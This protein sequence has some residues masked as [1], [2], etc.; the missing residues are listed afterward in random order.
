MH[1]HQYWWLAVFAFRLIAPPAWH[2][3]SHKILHVMIHR[4]LHLWPAL[5]HAHRLVRFAA[6]E[7]FMLVGLIIVHVLTESGHEDN[8]V[9]PAQE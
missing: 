4:A 9:H 1:L 6:P 7:V 2:L 5:H 8:E 3:V